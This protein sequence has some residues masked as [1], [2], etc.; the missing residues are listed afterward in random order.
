[1][2]AIGQLC[3]CEFCLIFY[4]AIARTD[5]ARSLGIST[6]IFQ[7]RPSSFCFGSIVSTEFKLNFPYTILWD[8]TSQIK[9]ITVDFFPQALAFHY[10][11]WQAIGSHLKPS[12]NHILCNSSAVQPS[13]HRPLG[14]IFNEAK[15]YY[16]FHQFY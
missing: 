11:Q 6:P 14:H 10:L 4:K 8:S 3:S 7:L 1:M 9:C 16:F 5:P 2:N 15:N 12:Q 13:T